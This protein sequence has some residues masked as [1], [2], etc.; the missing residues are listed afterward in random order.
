[1]C[2]AS[3]IPIGRPSLYRP[4]SRP[5]SSQKLLTTQVPSGNTHNPS[6]KFWTQSGPPPNEL[7]TQDVVYRRGAGSSAMTP[8]PMTRAK[9][10][11]PIPVIL[12][13]FMAI[14]LCRWVSIHGFHDARLPSIA[15]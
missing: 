15:H 13:R 4:T 14:S 3:I 1:M 7:P 5:A 11:A 2:V 8:R 9:P 10:A 12:N 6:A